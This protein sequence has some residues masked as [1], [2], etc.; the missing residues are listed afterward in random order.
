M[1]ATTAAEAAAAATQPPEPGDA[2]FSLALTQ[3]QRDIR[4]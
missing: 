4:D 3:D 1:Q 2:P